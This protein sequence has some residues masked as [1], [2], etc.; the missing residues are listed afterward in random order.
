MDDNTNHLSATDSA[1]VAELKAEG[2]AFY[3]Q[4]NLEA[5]A[6]KYSKALEIDDKNAII[7]CNR[8]ACRLGQ[9]RYAVL[10]LRWAEVIW[11]FLFNLH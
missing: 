2:N 4:K 3:L 7:Y 11:D 9:S 6:N 8:A 1:R 10:T 5:A